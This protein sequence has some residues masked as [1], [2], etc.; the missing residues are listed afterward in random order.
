[1]GGSRIGKSS[2]RIRAY[3]SYDELGAHLGVAEAASQNG[4]ADLGQLLLRLEHE[5]FIVQCE[6]ATP[7]TRLGPSPR[8]TARHV[9]RLETDIDHWSGEAGPLGSFVLQR[10]TTLAAELHVCRTVARRAERELWT[11]HETEAQRPELL[12]WANRVSDLLFAVAL[13]ANRR[14]GVTEVAPDYTV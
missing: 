5:L 13:V 7:S 1:V 9:K 3:G 14:A 11:L 8:I 4:G 2:S 6:L 10:G 12:Q